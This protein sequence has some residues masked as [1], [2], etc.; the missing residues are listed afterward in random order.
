[1]KEWLST[2]SRAELNKL[3]EMG[4][5]MYEKPATFWKRSDN[6]IADNLDTL[7]LISRTAEDRDK[8]VWGTSGSSPQ[9]RSPVGLWNAL[10][11]RSWAPCK[12]PLEGSSNELQCKVTPCWA[13]GQHRCRQ[14][15]PAP[16][17]KEDDA[18]SQ[19]TSERPV[20]ILFHPKLWNHRLS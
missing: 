4:C 7:W 12:R 20:G 13:Y 5:T 16:S 2:Q 1:M 14:R 18:R 17:R 9:T 3:T 15:N 6:E 11:V 19:N 10:L 8:A